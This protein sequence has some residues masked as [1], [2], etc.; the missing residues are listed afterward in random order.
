M[1]LITILLTHSRGGFLA[2]IA[3]L[4][5]IAWRSRTLIRAAF[6]LT[7]LV[8]L[9]FAFAPQHVIDR[10]A[11]IKQGSQE[12]SANARIISWTVATRMI[13]ANPLLGVGLRNFQNHWER[14]V[15]GLPVAKGGFAYVAHNSYLQ[16]WAE[17]GTPAFVIYLALL[18]SV[19]VTCRRVR[20]WTRARD[21]LWWASLYAN[22]FESVTFGFVIGAVFLNRGHFDLIYHDLALVTCLSR[23]TRK[24]LTATARAAHERGA[25]RGVVTIAWRAVAPGQS[26]LPRWGRTV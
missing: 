2:A 20:A 26:R 15:E 9:F 23:M 18:G 3:T 4:L 19:F 11:S 7:V 12:R 1:T 22:T 14:H 17:A 5:V 8:T 6:G 21:D 25:R 13:E 10:L 16:I 24:A